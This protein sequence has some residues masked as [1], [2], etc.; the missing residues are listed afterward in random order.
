MSAGK[1]LEGKSHA[2]KPHA[3]MLFAVI[4]VAL[5]VVASAGAGGFSHHPDVNGG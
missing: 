1:A 2:V 3:C 4:A 5:A